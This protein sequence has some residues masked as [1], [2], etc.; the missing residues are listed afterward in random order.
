[1]STIVAGAC[2]FIAVPALVGYAALGCLLVPIVLCL[3]A[4]ENR[5]KLRG[6]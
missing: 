2:G 5:P 1:M 4:R 3:L 6:E